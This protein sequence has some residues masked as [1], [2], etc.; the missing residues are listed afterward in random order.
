MN[1]LLAFEFAKRSHEIEYIDLWC[2]RY[3]YTCFRPLFG[4]KSLQTQQSNHRK[5]PSDIHAYSRCAS[6][7]IVAILP[8]STASTKSKITINAP[9][10]KCRRRKLWGISAKNRIRRRKKNQLI[11]LQALAIAISPEL[12]LLFLRAVCSVQHNAENKF[13]V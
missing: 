8:A 11:L 10:I 2:A 1:G 3:M 12:L 4:P 5:F 7:I 6:Q 9:V 13:S